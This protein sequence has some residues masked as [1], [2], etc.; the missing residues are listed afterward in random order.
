MQ[1]CEQYRPQKWA[2]V[3]GQA[4][5]VG[6]IEKLRKRGLAGRAYWISGQSGTGK[7]TIAR[8]LASEIA[9]DINVNELD[10]TGLTPAALREIELA[11]RMFGMG[12]KQG[13][14]YIVNESHGLTP[15]AIRQL[16]VMIESGV[17]AD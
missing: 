1:L 2:D 7:T 9:D 15:T 12:V 3:I 5:V 4:K 14:A 6:T 13:R 11:W 16:L 10:A 17:M 8:L